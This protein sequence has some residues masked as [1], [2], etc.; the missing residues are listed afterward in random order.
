MLLYCHFFENIECSAI[1]FS[2]F[3]KFIDS[4]HARKEKQSDLLTLNGE[5]ITNTIVIVRIEFR[6][7]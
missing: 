5:N 2:T 1:D 3:S 6:L 7:F 4:S